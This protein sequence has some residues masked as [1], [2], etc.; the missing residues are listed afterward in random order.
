MDTYM[1]KNSALVMLCSIENGPQLGKVTQ[2]LNHFWVGWWWILLII[3]HLDKLNESEVE[4]TQVVEAVATEIERLSSL[5]I[6][7]NTPNSH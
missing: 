7:S 6:H 3:G 2:K 5:E 1:Q 4:G